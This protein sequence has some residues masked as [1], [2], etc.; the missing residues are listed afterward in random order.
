MANTWIWI[1]RDSAGCESI[2]TFNVALRELIV[3]DATSVSPSCEGQTDGLIVLQDIDGGLGPYTVQLDNQQP[4]ISDTWPDTLSNVGVGDHTLTITNMDGCETEIDITL[5]AAMSGSID[6][7]P[8]ATLKLGDS[9]LITPVADN[10]AVNSSQ[11]DP[12]TILT[13]VSPFWFTPSATTTLLL[14]VYDSMGCIYQDEKLIT[15]LVDQRIYIPTIF[16]PNGD[17]ANDVFE[18]TTSSLSFPIFS[19][20]I[21]DRWGNNLYQDSTDPFTWDG[22]SRNKEA[23]PGVYVVRVLWK[24]EDDNIQAIVKDLTLIR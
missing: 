21:Y 15:V 8:D 2:D 12:A 7:G 24:D 22:I 14:T 19:I 13:G 23:L 17:Q 18:V 11:W 1:V 5:N 3:V 10:I 16:S 6:L 4:F 20:E 9:I